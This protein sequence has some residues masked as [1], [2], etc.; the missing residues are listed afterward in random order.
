M[1]VYNM[2]AVP[3][4]MRLEILDT[5]GAAGSSRRPAQGGGQL[6][7]RLSLGTYAIYSF[8]NGGTFMGKGIPPPL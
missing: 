7:H 6:M 2:R 5:V 4:D 3:S 1:I 8:R